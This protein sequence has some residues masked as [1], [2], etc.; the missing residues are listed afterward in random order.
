[1]R[2]Y[3]IKINITDGEILEKPKMI[4][5][6]T[7]IN[8]SYIYVE[9]YKDITTPIADISDFKVTMN[10]VKPNN[11]VDTL[12]AEIEGNKLKYKLPL[13]LLLIDGPYKIEF[14][15]KDKTLLEDNRI[16]SNSLKYTVKK[17]ILSD[18]NDDVI[19]DENY[20][21][22]LEL[23]DE[24][25]VLKDTYNNKKEFIFE[26]KGTE[27]NPI[28][29]NTLQDNLYIIQK[30]SYYK[31]DENDLKRVSD[32]KK[33]LLVNRGTASDQQVELMLID[34]ISIKTIVIADEN[35]ITSEYM[36]TSKILNYLLEMSNLSINSLDTI[37]KSLVGA[38]NE[39]LESINNVRQSAISEARVVTLVKENSINEARVINLIAEKSINTEGVIDLIAENSINENGVRNIIMEMI[40]TGVISGSYSISTNANITL[41]SV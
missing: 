28:I 9:L 7:D 8:T 21:I 35:I 11:I 5:Y 16:T 2:S 17:S 31:F 23:I 37:N 22:L 39:L 26:L 36:H 20:P 18:V 29:L 40:N 33:M 12:E 1:M 14:F 27:D 19:I 10:I 13:K 38:I 34:S 32:N 25:E 15:I 41:K 3:L 30:D 4:Y 6:N 24:V